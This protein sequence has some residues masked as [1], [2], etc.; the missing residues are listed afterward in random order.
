[1]QLSSLNLACELTW[2]SLWASTHNCLPVADLRYEA[3]GVSCENK[4]PDFNRRWGILWQTERGLSRQRVFR[5]FTLCTPK[6]FSASVLMPWA[7]CIFKL[8]QNLSLCPSVPS[9]L[10]FSAFLICWGF[11][12]P[13]VGAEV[14]QISKG[15][16][17]Y[18]PLDSE[19][20]WARQLRNLFFFLLVASIP[21]FQGNKNVRILV[22]DLPF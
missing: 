16:V 21:I 13:A 20:V 22:I 4:A 19:N 12:F 18:S 9:W 17:D 6:A 5:C 3:R 8:G 2:G 1:M 15:V 10:E 14:L 11:S 7:V